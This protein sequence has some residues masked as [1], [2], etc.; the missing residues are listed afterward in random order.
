MVEFRISGFLLTSI[1]VYPPE[2]ESSIQNRTM[3]YAK[4]SQFAWYSNERNTGPYNQLP[5]T[6]NQLSICKTNPNKAN[7]W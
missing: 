5:I 2:A 6:S 4:Q 1:Q 7:L 3:N